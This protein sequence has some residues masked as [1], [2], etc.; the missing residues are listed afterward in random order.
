MSYLP[1]TEAD[2]V[3][4]L[5]NF[6]AQ[7]G[8]SGV[9][10]GFDPD[11]VTSITAAFTAFDTAYRAHLNSQE[12]A[13]SARLA[14]E[15]TKT[16]LLEHVRAAVKRLQA[17]PAMTDQVRQLYGMTVPTDGKVP[18]P[19]PTTRPVGIIETGDRLQHVLRVVDATTPTSRARPAGVI[20]CE[21]WLKI[22][23][24]VPTGPSETTMVGLHTGTQFLHTFAESD[25][26]KLAHYMLRWVNTRG[27]K[28]PW[29]ETVS[30]TIAA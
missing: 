11:E 8:T 18:A 20:G 30:V 27:Q 17:S 5:I 6:T 21:V 19:A 10:Y 9:T 28:G 26:G 22:G 29:S 25:G 16:A 12:S 7:L 2:L 1:T 3:Q 23:G 24:L 4:W 15:T 13:R 14:K